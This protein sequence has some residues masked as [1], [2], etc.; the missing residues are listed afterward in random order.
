MASTT[1]L[2]C[3]DKNVS[4]ADLAGICN[5]PHSCFSPLQCCTHERAR[6]CTCHHRTC[7]QEGLPQVCQDDFVLDWRGSGQMLKSL[8]HMLLLALHIHVLSLW[9]CSVR[10]IQAAAEVLKSFVSSALKSSKRQPHSTRRFS[11]RIEGGKVRH[12]RQLTFIK[13]REWQ[14]CRVSLLMHH[15]RLKVTPSMKLPSTAMRQWFGATSTAA[16]GKNV[17]LPM[18]RCCSDHQSAL[19]VDHHARNLINAKHQC[20]AMAAPLHVQ[21]GC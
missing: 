5:H 12:V 16:R 4:R 18:L 13:A 15:L 21:T 7:C 3:I 11:I 20:A 17:C 2:I 19:L 1:F 9:H 10:C 6:P 8:I 14:W